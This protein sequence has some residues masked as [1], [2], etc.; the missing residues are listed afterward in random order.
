MIAPETLLKMHPLDAVRAQIQEQVR[1]PLQA[2][3][4]KIEKPVSLGGLRTQIFATIDKK[5]AP[6]ELWDRTGG[7]MFEYDRLDLGNF[8]Q[9][10]NTAL[11]S[12]L[13]TG[14]VDLLR[15]LLNPRDIVVDD[16]DI[17]PAVYTQLGSAEIMAAEESYR[18]IG[19][20]TMTING[21]ALEI[22]TLVRNKTFTL[23]FTSNF[24]SSTVLGDLIMHLNLSNPGLPKAVLAAMV[25]IGLPEQ[26][27]ADHDGDNTRVLLTFN[28]FPYVGSIYATYQRRSFPKTFRNAIKI[29]GGAISNTSQLA[30]PLSGLMGCTITAADIAPQPMPNQALNSK[31]KVSVNFHGESLAYVG[32]ILVEYNRTV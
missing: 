3:H 21:Q 29:A 7:F 8:V 25:S 18:W 11:P 1:A 16:D 24:K 9:G 17:V 10:M 31:Q 6:V 27:G 12:Q 22:S 5:R 26:M 30:G 14:S 19:S 4:L 15:A 32:S 28:G 20:M 13:P 23:S 2:I